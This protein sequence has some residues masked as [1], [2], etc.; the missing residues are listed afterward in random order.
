[1]DFGLAK[2]V[3]PRERAGTICGTLQYMGKKQA[4]NSFRPVATKIKCSVDRLSLSEGRVIFR[5]ERY[6]FF[7]LGGGGNP[8]TGW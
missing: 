5:I 3:K 6:A 2:L 1:M 8:K 4:L 7:F